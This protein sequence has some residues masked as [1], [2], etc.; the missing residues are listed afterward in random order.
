MNFQCSNGTEEAVVPK[1]GF[2][3]RIAG[4]KHLVTAIR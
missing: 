2:A 1:P 4:M 3:D